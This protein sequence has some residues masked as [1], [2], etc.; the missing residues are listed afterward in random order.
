MQIKKKLPGI[1]SDAPSRP[2][3]DKD[4]VFC[5]SHYDGTLFPLRRGH[6]HISNL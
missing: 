1:L 3:R 5:S 6:F 4:A 2:I